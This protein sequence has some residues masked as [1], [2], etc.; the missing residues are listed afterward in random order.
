MDVVIVT[1]PNC[2]WC[3]EVERL[4]T[5]LNLDYDLQHLD[6]GEAQAEFC[7]R[8]NVSTFPQVFV[9]KERLGGHDDTLCWIQT[10]GWIR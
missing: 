3:R 1:K 7:R 9:D 6:T 10:G 5:Q 8:H 4:L 2:Q